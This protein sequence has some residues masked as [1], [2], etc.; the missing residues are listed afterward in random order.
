MTCTFCEYYEATLEIMMMMESMPT[1]VCVRCES[2]M[3][4]PHYIVAEADTRN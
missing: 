3:T 1:Y 2:R 4:T